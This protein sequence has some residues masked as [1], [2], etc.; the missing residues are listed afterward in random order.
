MAKTPLCKMCSTRSRTIGSLNP[1]AKRETI[2]YILF[3]NGLRVGKKKYGR[4]VIVT[5]DKAPNNFAFVRK[6]HYIDCLITEL[7]IDNSLG[8]PTYTST[9]SQNWWIFFK[10]EKRR[11]KNKNKLQRPERVLPEIILFWWKLAR[12]QTINSPLEKDEN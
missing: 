9:K 4:N 5:A 3:P 2:T 8:N 7:G 6:W 10:L 1:W 11:N 12:H